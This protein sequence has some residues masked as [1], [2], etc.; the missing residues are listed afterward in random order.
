MKKYIKFLGGAA[1]CIMMLTACGEN[2][3]QTYPESSVASEQ[4]STDIRYC[5][6]LVNGVLKT[7]SNQMFDT[8]GENGEGTTKVWHNSYKTGYSQKCGLTGWANS[9]NGTYHVSTNN[10]YGTYRWSHYYRMI[11]N[12]NNAIQS[13]NEY[14]P[15]QDVSNNNLK[16]FYLAQVYTLRA[17]AYM[18]LTELFCRRWSDSRNGESR[19]VVLRLDT[20]A[21]P[22]PASSEGEVIAQIYSDLDTALQKF[23]SCGVDRSELWEVNSDVAHAIYSRIALWREDWQ[24]AATHA[25]AARKNYRLMNNDEYHAGFCNEN[26][27][28][29]WSLYSSTDE[30]LYYYGYFAYTASN[31]SASIC[32]TY[33]FAIDKFL[34]ESIPDTDSR[35]DLYLAPTPEEYAES[36]INK[37]TG[38]ATTGT[39]FSRVWND[40][41]KY[42][43]NDGSSVSYIYIYMQT[44]VRTDG[45]PGIGQL[46]LAR[47]AEMYYNEA[48]AQ[49][50]MGN[51][52]AAQ[53]LLEDVVK[54]FDADYT[55]AL[56]GED[57][58]NE[59]KKYRNFDL[60]LEGYSYFD[61][62]RWGG[63]R[64]RV[65][66]ADGGNWHATFAG[67]AKP[68]DHNYWSWCIPQAETNYNEFI[69]LNIE[70]DNWSKNDPS[71]W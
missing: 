18:Q 62:K 1:I 56:T 41:G 6:Y 2:Y 23:N 8:Q 14:D 42:L 3:L 20:S 28:W 63:D 30:T 57:L 68:S 49:Y 10:A 35:K 40:Y 71:T 17:Y 53:S 48:E 4:A 12:A 66:L 38:Q 13:I 31:S 55:C 21:D 46:N 9:I 58:F 16:E 45:Q 60:L 69:N 25:A 70:P 37:T 54:P 65:S 67:V 11:L 61:E 19:G 27:E 43:Y 36:G 34:Y 15:G 52:S 39:F 26:P 59:I 5:K 50:K 29:I 64:V 22:M 33:P 32:R 44:K 24:T 51:T 7:M 47:A